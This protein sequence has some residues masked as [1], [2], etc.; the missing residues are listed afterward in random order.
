MY[1]YFHT[2]NV[3][4]REDYVKRENQEETVEEGYASC[5]NNE[6]DDNETTNSVNTPDSCNHDNQCN[7][8]EYRGDYVN[9]E[10]DINYDSIQD[11]ISKQ[12]TIN[13]NNIDNFNIVNATLTSIN[14][15]TKTLIN[16]QEKFNKNIT[17]LNKFKSFIEKNKKDYLKICKNRRENNVWSRRL[18]NTGI[19]K[20]Y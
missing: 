10:N 14:N 16:N 6:V 17:N 2:G 3:D 1:G 4:Y 20:Y 11:F 8:V 19:I 15:T 12:I 18:R 9:Q 13:S 5:H 7:S